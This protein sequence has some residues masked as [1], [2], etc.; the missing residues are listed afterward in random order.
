M[1]WAVTWFSHPPNGA[2]L[3]GDTLEEELCSA[4]CPDPR[5]AL[6]MPSPP[7]PCCT[8]TP[9][10]CPFASLAVNK[11]GKGPWGSQVGSTHP[12]QIKTWHVCLDAAS[13][14]QLGK[15]TGPPGEPM[16]SLASRQ[17][18]STIPS[19]GAW[20]SADKTASH[21]KATAFQA[22]PLAAAY[23]G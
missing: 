7:P 17:K 11:I 13:A 14:A 20:L 22:D 5:S 6:V 8:Q 2:H 4:R 15:T 23:A 9:P 16:D 3:A 1:I 12:Q 10:E 18:D 19:Q 21:P